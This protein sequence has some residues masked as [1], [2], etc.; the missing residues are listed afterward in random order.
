MFIRSLV[1]RYWVVYIF[2][3]LRMLL[4]TSVYNFLCGYVIL[5]GIYLGSSA[6][7]ESAY[8]AGNPGLIPG[9][10]RS[11][12][13]G[14][15]YPLQYSWASLV[16]QMV[17]NLPAMWKTWVRSLGWEDPLEKGMATH[18]S[19]LAWR[20]PVDRGA[21]RVRQRMESERVRHNWVTKYST[22]TSWNKFCFY[23]HFREWGLETLLKQLADKWL[24]GSEP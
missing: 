2:W 1:G 13:E 18:S 24:T 22:V 3:I 23:S 11:A 20:I 5:L 4:W 16:V 14:I 9:L 15:F 8:N 21:W 7:K 12:G 19:I 10:G 6:G 17:K